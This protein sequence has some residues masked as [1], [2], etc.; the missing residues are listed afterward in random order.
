MK[1]IIDNVNE[2][3][4]SSRLA[5]HSSLVLLTSLYVMYLHKVGLWYLGSYKDLFFFIISLSLFLVHI[6]IFVSCEIVVRRFELT[7]LLIKYR[8]CEFS[9]N[10]KE[11]IRVTDLFLKTLLYIDIVILILYVVG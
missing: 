5:Y 3:T 2:N 9:N 7:R 1:L 10:L 6:V 11:D 8:D 4:N